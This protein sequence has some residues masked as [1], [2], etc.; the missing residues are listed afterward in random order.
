MSANAR[1]GVPGCVRVRLS[2]CE[3]SVEPAPVTASSSALRVFETRDHALSVSLRLGL[4]LGL[5]LSVLLLPFASWACVCVCLLF[6]VGSSA[7]ALRVKLVVTIEL[8]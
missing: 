7:C 4:A 1:T 8:C 3:W 6:N 5:S 2:C